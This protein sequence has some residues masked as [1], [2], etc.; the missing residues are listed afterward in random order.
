M[1]LIGLYSDRK[2]ERGKMTLT[3]S[4]ATEATLSAF[5]DGKTHCGFSEY[6]TIT[7][8]TLTTPIPLDDADVV[9]N[10][11]DYKAILTLKDNTDPAEPKRIRIA[12]P[13]P[14]LNVADG[15]IA[16]KGDRYVFIPKTAATG[17]V[18][19]DGDTLAGQV[20]TLLGLATGDVVWMSGSFAYKK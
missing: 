16:R 7:E 8:G 13:A 9:E 12:V 11:K 15:F 3:N 4:G 17:E 2:G 20:A 19:L 10:D 14:R 18:G 5:L 6:E 1:K